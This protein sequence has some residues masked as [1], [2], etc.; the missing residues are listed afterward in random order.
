M[1]AEALIRAVRGHVIGEDDDVIF[2]GGATAAGE[3]VT[4]ESAL[5]VAAVYACVST[6]GAAVRAMPLEVDL[7]SGNGVL[8]QQRSSR[9]WGLLHDQPNPEQPAGEMW[10]GTTWDLLLRGNGFLFP[11]RE[12]SGRV[13][14]LW[15]LPVGRVEVG[16]DWRTGRKVYQVSAGDSRDAVRFSGMTTDLIHIKGDP[17]PDPLLGVPVIRR[18]RED[19]GRS[20]SEDRHAA[21]MMRNQGRPSGL[22]SVKGRLDPERKKRLAADWD[23]AHGG[24]RRAGRTAVLEEEATWEP[25]VMTAADMELVR[26]RSIS[27]ENVAIAFRLPGDMLLAGAQ[28]NL[29]YSSDA[30]RDLRLVKWAAMPWATRIQQALE[31]SG[32]LPWG[33]TGNKPGVLRP[34]FNPDA[35]HK[36]DIKTRYEAYKLAADAGWITGNE[37]RQLENYEALTGLDRVKPQIDP[38]PAKRNGHRP[39]VRLEQT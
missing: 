20:L 26:Q 22:L 21:T 2:G 36:T 1:I 14:H 10:E 19:I 18:L 23:A 3:R 39:E 4:A 31:A 9:L 15:P 13:R 35:L 12:P 25:V 37:I 5:K 34:R 7:D 17:G 27:R 16:R 38:E 28:A 32:L 11:E 33:V 6:I 29:H 30:S 24:A 8:R